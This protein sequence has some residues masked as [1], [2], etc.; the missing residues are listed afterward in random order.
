MSR[1]GY[2]SDENC[3]RE[4]KRHAEQLGYP[5]PN[6]G[7]Y[8]DCSCDQAYFRGYE[9]AE[10]RERERRE[11]EEEQRYLEYKLQQERELQREYE[12]QLEYA[13]LQE[14]EQNRE[15]KEK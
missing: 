2:D 8:S 5:D 6:Y 12:E 11:E 7:R 1:W 13:R 9:E 10:R 4:G 15:E 3:R 14:Y